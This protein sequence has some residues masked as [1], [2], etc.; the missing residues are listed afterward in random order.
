F[1]AIVFGRIENI[2]L[3]RGCCNVI[4]KHRNQVG[5]PGRDARLKLAQA[6]I[7]KTSDEELSTCSANS[8]RHLFSFLNVTAL[9]RRYLVHAALINNMKFEAPKNKTNSLVPRELHLLYEFVYGF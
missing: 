2:S 1:I 5:F 3:D 7:V 6:S 4:Y 8:F 9:C